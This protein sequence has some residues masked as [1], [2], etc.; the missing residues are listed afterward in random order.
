LPYA[1]FNGVALAQGEN[2]KNLSFECLVGVALVFA[3]LKGDAFASSSKDIPM[4]DTNWIN[5]KLSQ[6]QAD[7]KSFMH[8]HKNVAK[9]DPTS[10]APLQKLT[11]FSPESI[12]SLDFVTQKDFAQKSSGAGLMHGR[13]AIQTND[14]AANLVEDLKLTTPQSMED[15]HLTQATL[16]ESPWSDDY[17]PIYRGGIATRYADPNFPNS[18][19]WATNVNYVS[20]GACSVDQLSPAEK[21][22]F[23]VGDDHNSLTRSAVF[24]GQS[25]YNQYGKVETWMGICHGWAPASIMLPRPPHPVKLIAADGHTPILFYPSDIK[26][27][28]SML[29]AKGSTKVK[30]I[31]GRC[32]IKTPSE[33]QNGRVLNN[34]CFDTNPGTWHLA[35]V[36]Q[37]GVAKRSFV[38]DATYDYEVWNQPA[39]G[40]QYSY[41]NPQIMR[42]SATLKDAM[43]PISAFTQDRFY[44]Y[45]SSKAKYVVGIA[46]KFIY[47]AE[48]NP[49]PESFNKPENDRRIAVNYL[50]DLELD[51][52]YQIIGGEWY[53]R[54]H[55]DFLWVPIKNTEAM[56]VGDDY[57]NGQPTAFHPGWDGKSILPDLWRRA[58]IGSSAYGQPLG[59]IVETLGVVS[60]LTN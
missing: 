12:Q 22:D 33:D 2:M 56:A 40:Y 32:N 49:K 51:E 43:V 7:P 37:I 13:A 48:T 59:A 58:A 31:G 8:N 1:F 20:E 45:R 18:T 23:L 9:Y 19:D 50:Y 26:A 57:L 47:I 4:L 3:T 6:F 34:D 15:A 27:L 28:S 38:L 25:Y 16:E 14:L 41:F 35:V 5:D 36:N 30:F 44:R 42:T 21:Y 29:W 17:W 53:H 60:N 11:H 24:E 54:E 39:L 55:P 46:M 10:L 52:N